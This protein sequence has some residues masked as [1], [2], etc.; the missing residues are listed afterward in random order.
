MPTD[1]IDLESPTRPAQAAGTSVPTDAALL[2]TLAASALAACG[3]G[4]DSALPSA[5]QSVGPDTPRRH[6]LGANP[7]AVPAASAPAPLPSPS[8]LMN[9][10]E[11]AYSHYFPGPQ[12][13]LVQAPY[14]YRFYPATGNYVG[15]ANGRV[16][17][18]G[19]VAGG[20]PDVV[21]VGAV[22]DFAARVAALSFPADDAMAARFLGQATLG[23][24]DADITAVRM[25]GYD[26]WL[27]AE[28]AKPPS[29]SNWQYLIN[30]GFAANPDN[31]ASSAGSDPAI[32]QRLI[33]A[34]DSLRQRV[35][36]ALSEILVVGFD[37]LTGPWKQFKLAAW[38]D[39]LATHAFGNYRTLL[40]AVT[41]NAAMGQYLSVAG[42]QK[43]D[44]VTGRLPDENYAREVMQLFSIGLYELNADGTPRLGANGQPIETYTQDTVTQ[45]ARVFT[46]WGLDNSPFETGPEV[47]AR[48]MV[49]TAGR[50]STLAVSALG[51][52]IPAGTDGTVA[53]RMTL[54]RLAAHSNVGPFI[55]R[56][57]IQ[58]LVTSNPSPAYVARV[59]AAFADNGRGVRGDLS[60]VVRAVLIDD[61]ARDP[62]RSTDPSFGKLR[63]PLVRFLQWARSF[64]LSSTSGDWQVGNLGD[65]GTRLGQSP[66]R[67][68]SVFNWFRPGFA[69]AGT[70]IGAAGL[71]APEFQIADES[72]VAGYL[73]FMQSAI[74]ALRNDLTTTYAAE[75]ALADDPAAL[76]DRVQLLLCGKAL[77]ASTRSTIINAVTS[78]AVTTSTGRANRVYV[79]IMLVMASADYLVQK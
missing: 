17:I 50:H 15:T 42:N 24:T 47:M 53:L 74:P 51:M 39:L 25:V 21:D 79:A 14:T 11:K 37:G 52:T 45:L 67:A 5:F 55:G 66:L 70:A 33:S 9:W 43:E 30:K 19:P 76:V 35:A 10:A 12:S 63:E 59:A 31:K 60:A 32:W 4:S 34:P 72:S 62:N 38:W 69:P 64:K 40:E 7:P 18:F 54:D 68:P 29:T 61:E 58:R 23:V 6:T 16:Y 2:A 26:A 1:T 73:N 28:F 36:L 49:L 78:I 22:A 56:Q 65:N 57:L 8:E 44:P 3:G 75:L 20:G 41:L 71:V 27:T 48:P 13:D 77:Q 46:G